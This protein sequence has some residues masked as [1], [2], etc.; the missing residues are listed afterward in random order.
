VAAKMW[1]EKYR[2]GKIIFENSEQT[3]SKNNWNNNM[4][5]TVRLM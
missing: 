2:D 5:A 3:D 1:E 4:R